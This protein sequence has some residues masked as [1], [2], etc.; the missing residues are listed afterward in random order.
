[1]KKPL[2]QLVNSDGE[3]AHIASE[4]I[5]IEI[6]YWLFAMISQGI[7]IS[8]EAVCIASSRPLVREVLCLIALLI[9][10]MLNT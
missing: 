1:M 4:N 3:L 10:L 8:F 7:R 5:L 9:K 2:L 6:S